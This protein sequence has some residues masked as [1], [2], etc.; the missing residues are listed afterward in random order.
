MREDDINFHI[1]SIVIFSLTPIKRI[2]YI[3]SRKG[4]VRWSS[5]PR[6]TGRVQGV[7][8][9]FLHTYIKGSYP[10]PFP[11]PF[12]PALALAGKRQEDTWTR[13]DMIRQPV[14]IRWEDQESYVS[15]IVPT[16]VPTNVPSNKGIYIYCY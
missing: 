6:I 9:W 2:K 10:L 15:M 13:Y 1:Y 16:I 8:I 7:M 14:Y 3:L 12:S 5:L 4:P 11:L